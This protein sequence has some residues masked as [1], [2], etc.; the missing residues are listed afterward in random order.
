VDQRKRDHV[1]LLF[2]EHLRLRKIP[3]KEPKNMATVSAGKRPMD[4]PT[5][6]TAG[7][8]PKAADTGELLAL[9]CDTGFGAIPPGKLRPGD[10]V[11]ELY[12]A[13]RLSATVEIVRDDGDGE[14]V[15]LRYDE[16]DNAADAQDRTVRLTQLRCVP[17]VAGD[18][19]DLARDRT[20]GVLG[21]GLPLPAGALVPHKGEKVEMW[22]DD[23]E[24]GD[25]GETAGW[26]PVRVDDVNE[27]DDTFTL[28]YDDD[29]V[30]Y[31]VPM[32]NVRPH[33]M[34]SAALKCFL[35]KLG[36]QILQP[37]P[38]AVE[39][40]RLKGTFTALEEALPA[41]QQ[42]ETHAKDALALEQRSLET[43]RLEAEQATAEAEAARNARGDAEEA[44]RQA[45]GRLRDLPLGE[46]F[47]AEYEQREEYFQQQRDSFAQT[48]REEERAVDLER[49]ADA[50]L[51][52]ARVSCGHAQTVA[53]QASFA[54]QAQHDA[55]V[56]ARGKY[57]DYVKALNMVEA[58]IAA[59]TTA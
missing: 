5:E 28:R 10:K 49:T 36:G 46:V 6:A 50:E 41:L 13:Q 40:E 39:R 51:M 11:Q 9:G 14:K 56:A 43:A 17:P 7:K 2:E 30:H 55:I 35:C 20:L 38:A 31:H 1:R 47:G 37:L 52:R 29:H 58:G 15:I 22:W 12:N 48:K 4:S 44:T 42:A 33:W 32:K 18:L 27:A 19:D 54:V 25:D 53:A 23:A 59:N 34:W 21:S 3:G 45:H 8:R 24:N 57:G 16:L 26:W